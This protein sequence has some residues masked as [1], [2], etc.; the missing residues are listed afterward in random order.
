MPGLG[1][2]VETVELPLTPVDPAGLPDHAVVQHALCRPGAV[3]DLERPLRPTDRPA[4]GGNPVFLVEQHRAHAEPRK[5]ERRGKPDRSG[6]DDH[7]RARF[8]FPGS[9]GP[10][11]AV[12]ERGPGDHPCC[13]GTR[14]SSEGWRNRA[15]PAAAW[16][17][18]AP[19][20]GKTPRLAGDM[21]PEH[22]AHHE[23][24][25]RRLPAL[26]VEVIGEHGGKL[27]RRVSP[28]L[29]LP[30]IV[31]FG[32][33][34]GCRASGGR[35]PRAGPAGH[36]RRPPAGS[37]T[38]PHARTR[39]RSRPGPAGPGAAPSRFRPRGSPGAGTSGS[40]TTS[41]SSTA[42]SSRSNWPSPPRSS[43]ASS[44]FRP[45]SRLSAA[46]CRSPT[47]S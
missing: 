12:C 23:R 44:A 7:D 11:P 35:R 31:K 19:D 18:P 39:G 38:R 1:Q 37:G 3:Q 42:S 40:S 16:V 4:A 34:A 10:G 45:P 28:D 2:Q 13:S 30:Q 41:R 25:M 29:Y 9:D 32:M 27:P 26:L 22:R 24:A 17:G 36:R 20:R 6:A 47:R 5:F 14:A 15:E 8:R 46:G 21:G 43:T 33:R